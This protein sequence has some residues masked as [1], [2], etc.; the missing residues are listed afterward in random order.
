MIQ[1][2]DHKYFHLYN[3]NISY[4]MYIMPNNELGHLYYGKNLGKL[5]A[6][7]LSYLAFHD[8]R[9]AEITEFDPKLKD[10]SLADRMQEFPIFGS[11]DYREGAVEIKKGH[12]YLYPDFKFA[13]YEL[14]KGKKREKYPVAYGNDCENLV[15]KLADKERGLELNLFYTI[16]DNSSAIVR[17]TEIINLSEDDYYLEKANSL[18]LDLPSADYDFLQLSGAWIKERHLVTRPLKQG[19]TK[20]E[21]LR[22]ATSHQANP[23]V[24]LIDKKASNN[25]GEIY[26]SNLIY[27]GNF[28]SQVQVD[29]WHTSR[30]MTG[31]NDQHFEYLLKPKDKF[32]TPEA[33]LFYTKL[34]YNGLMN[35]THSFVKNHV[36][37]SKWRSRKRP[38][39][40]NNWEATY[41]DFN[42]EKLLKL[43]KTAKDLGIECFVLDDGWFG[44]R[45]DDTT[46]LGNW[47]INKKK[48][49]FG[50]KHFSKQIHHLGMQFGLWFEPEMVSADTPIFKQHPDWVVHHPYPR[51]SVGR[52]QYVLDFTNPE[53]VDNI[54][55]QMSAI[56]EDADVDFIK[57][58]MNRHISEAYSPYLQKNKRPQGEFYPRFI[59]GVYDLN[60]KLLTSYPDLLIEGC[61]SG[62]GRFDLGILYYSPQIWPSDDSD[63]VERLDIMTGTLLAYPLSCFSN[64]VSAVP[65]HQVGR[66]ESLKYRQDFN[67][68][69][70]LGYELDLNKLSKDEK[71][72]IKEHIAK[73]K[74]NRNLLVN[75]NFNFLQPIGDRQNTYS[76]SIGNKQE[77]FVAFYRKLAKP[78]E[79]LDQYLNLPVIDS[80]CQ[81]Q[82]DDQWEI[83]GNVLKN[84]GLRL[85]YQLNGWNENSAQLSGD[86]QSKIFHLKRN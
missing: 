2:I 52:N 63:A 80:N 1:I 32:K 27:S 83:S 67:F 13:S 77:Q 31:I 70:P 41:F 74:E 62:G 85:P 76:W 60:H 47:T 71:E 43:A 23:F 29:E 7:D 36:I 81:Y 26:A 24:A 20:V 48:F 50:I 69:G 10:F 21:S 9:G 35:E 55:N 57:W 75:G 59:Q 51:Y 78:N 33:V 8:N 54:Y 15:V 65:N 49:P 18:S 22:G 45:D 79:S 28:V 16:F 39:V 34:G 4:V 25:S 40:I 44:R 11:S 42:E 17:H 14:S 72:A 12:E 56:I 73:Y 86:F 3:K 6:S 37:A 64:H 5:T 53:V 61:A 58:D 68:F 82:I 46:S 19:I 30:L 38:V 66:I 84:F